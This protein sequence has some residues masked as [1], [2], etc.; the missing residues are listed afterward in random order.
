[1]DKWEAKLAEATAS[2]P[3]NIPGA[4][5]LVVNSEG[6]HTILVKPCVYSLRSDS[7]PVADAGP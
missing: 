2:G 6:M 4:I 5:G 3:E 7:E 1:M